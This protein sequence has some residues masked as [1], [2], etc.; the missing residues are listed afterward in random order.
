MTDFAAVATRVRPHWTIEPDVAFLNHGSFGAC[1][2]AV[3]DHQAAVRARLEAQPMRFFVREL[4]DELDRTR[5]ALAP[6]LGAEAEDLAFVPNATTGV[7]AVLRSRRFEPGDEILVTDHGYNACTNV[8]RFVADRWGARVVVAEL[9]FPLRDPGEVVQAVLGA[10]SERTRFALLD[11]VTSPSGLVLPVRELGAALAERGVDVMIDGA[12]APGMLA[13]DLPSLGVPFWTGNFHKWP[14]APKGAAVLWVR[15]DRQAEVRPAVLS[16]GANAEVPGRSR[17]LL[18]FDWMGTND[19]SAVLTM[20][21][22]VECVGAL[23]PGGWPA[24]REHIHGLASYGRDVLAEALGTTPPAPDAMLG[25][26]AALVLPPRP[27]RA[28]EGQAVLDV[29]PLAERLAREDRIEV[30]VMGV[31]GARLVRLV[32]LSAH[33]YNSPDD[34]ARLADALPRLLAEEQAGVETRP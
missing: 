18:E 17:Y 8:A 29:D 10:V 24:V 13:L 7:N 14:C 33:L 19:P 26:L 22:A 20:P 30:P 4:Q 32:R 1:P 23:M 9:P 16:H 3:L 15:R 21:T 28:D 2:R 6:F 31:P 5:E 27:P 34:Y 25:S 12:H 11:H